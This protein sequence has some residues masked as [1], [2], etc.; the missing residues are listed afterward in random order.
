VDM[1]ATDLVG[2]NGINRVLF[3]IHVSARC[4]PSK[5]RITPFDSRYGLLHMFNASGTKD[6]FNFE[7]F[8]VQKRAGLTFIQQTFVYYVVIRVLRTRKNA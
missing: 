2:I 3:S 5:P 8:V 6:G 1:H 4:V 7:V